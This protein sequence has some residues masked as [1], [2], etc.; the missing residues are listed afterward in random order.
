[1]IITATLSS[2]KPKKALMSP[3][4]AQW[5]RLMG[6]LVSAG[7]VG[8]NLP[9]RRGSDKLLST[10]QSRARSKRPYSWRFLG[11]TL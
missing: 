11:A 6:P 3:A 7:E 2:I 4:R 8:S 9:E 10:A 1:M 5:Y